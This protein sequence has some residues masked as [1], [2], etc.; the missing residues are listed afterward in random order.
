M[1]PL[2]NE[3]AKQNSTFNPESDIQAHIIGQQN[4]QIIDLMRRAAVAEMQGASNTRDPELHNRLEAAASDLLVAKSTLSK[5]KYDLDGSQELVKAL[6]ISNDKLVIEQQDVKKAL[7]TS[8]ETNSKLGIA[9]KALRA[10]GATIESPLAT[11]LAAPLDIP[12]IKADQIQIKLNH[13]NMQK[14]SYKQQLKVARARLAEAK[15]GK[16]EIVYRYIK[17]QDL[18][19]LTFTITRNRLDTGAYAVSKETYGYV[20]ERLTEGVYTF[21][22]VMSQVAVIT[23]ILALRSTMR[24]KDVID[25]IQAEVGMSEIT[26]GIISSIINGRLADEKLVSTIQ[27]KM[28]YQQQHE[29]QEV[30]FRE[31]EQIKYYFSMQETLSK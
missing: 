3:V 28:T 25:Q 10:E 26:R 29:F 5:V 21:N 8:Q 30:M 18:T 23:K 7:K 6:N 2:L 27:S 15:S 31:Y 20:R 24:P 16:G 14:G 1:I 12:N 17:N 22:P 19:G 13:S 9:I 4:D 11:P